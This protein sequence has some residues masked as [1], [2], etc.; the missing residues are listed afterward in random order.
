MAAWETQIVLFSLNDFI[1]ALPKIVESGSWLALDSP[2]A[3]A[4]DRQLIRAYSALVYRLV[5]KQL[6]FTLFPLSFPHSP[7]PQY[8]SP[9]Y[10]SSANYSVIKRCYHWG[11]SL[12]PKL[13]YSLLTASIT[14]CITGRCSFVRSCISQQSPRVPLGTASQY[15]LN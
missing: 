7:S 13:R 8:L 9:T 2:L 14:Y 15:A 3:P 1:L 12:L 11:F 5:E 6:T 10:R 4:L